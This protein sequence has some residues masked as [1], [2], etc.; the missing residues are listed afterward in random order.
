MCSFISIINNGSY[1]SHIL[2]DPYSVYQN[3]WDDALFG[4]GKNI[5]SFF[6]SE[7]FFVSYLTLS[8]T[9]NPFSTPSSF[10]CVLL[11]KLDEQNFVN[12]NPMHL[13]NKITTKSPLKFMQMF[14]VIQNIETNS[15]YTKKLFLRILWIFMHKHS[16]QKLRKNIQ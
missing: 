1:V 12:S 14:A 13:L 16:F 9:L 2:Y 5:H 10:S 15:L 3:L 4:H 11:V 6:G 7:I 8:W